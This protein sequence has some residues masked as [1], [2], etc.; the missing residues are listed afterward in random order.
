MTASSA[1]NFNHHVTNESLAEVSY[2]L[3]RE[4]IIRGVRYAGERLRIEKLK[5]I[6]GVGPTPLREALQRLSSEQ[7]VEAQENRGF[8]VAQMD[9]TDFA[10]LNFARTEIEKIALRRS[11]LLG[12][13]EWESRV[14]AATYMMAKADA[15]LSD[16]DTLG[17]DDEWESANNA[18]HSAMVSACDSRWL[19][20]TRG[21]LQDM[22][23]RYRRAS[24]HS[25]LGHRSTAN[26]HC[27]IS[28][29]VLAKDADRACMLT[30]QHFVATLNILLEKQSD[31]ADMFN[32]KELRVE[33]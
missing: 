5:T 13:H 3:L 22:C 1:T 15:R 12:G 31:Q 9:L 19:L 11:I 33:K 23:E 6:Y 20:M 29:A 30:T 14:V 8:I 24:L 2:R 26:E 27:Q 28:E 32:P 7:L 17:H 21:R 10:D 16:E 4:D 25:T 18:F